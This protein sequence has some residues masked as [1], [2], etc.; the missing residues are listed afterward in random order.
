M[1]SLNGID[2][3]V[4]KFPDG[5]SQVWKLPNIP[6]L[7][8][9]IEW[10]FQHE[11]EIMYLAQLV[12]LLRTEGTQRLTLHMPFLPYGRQDKAI[13]NESTFALHTFAAILNGL[14]FDK[15]TS[16]DVH[17][18]VAAAFLIDNFKNDFPY[19]EIEKTVKEVNPDVI[20]FPDKGARE[21]YGKELAFLGK[22]HIFGEKER[23]QQTGYI[24]KYNLDATYGNLVQ[25]RNVLIVDDICDGG[26]TFV[27][28][29]EALLTSGAKSVNLYTTHGIYSKGLKPL[30]AAKIERVFDRRGEI[31]T[32]PG[33]D[34]IVYK[35]IK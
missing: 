21:R 24:T 12:H 5:T 4:T 8:S 6:L 16:V 23:D 10:N 20:C 28:L 7:E 13:T 32:Y 9:N 30:K 17:N 3:E 26:G 2:I 25:D 34:A 14:R 35:E 29:S 15:V 19:Y 31:S 22:V 33:T 11:G 27:K 1:I 18:S